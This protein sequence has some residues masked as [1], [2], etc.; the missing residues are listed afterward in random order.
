MTYDVVARAQVVEVGNRCREALAAGISNPLDAE[1]EHCFG[2]GTYARIMK[3]A[4]GSV[5]QG[6]SHLHSTITVMLKGRA[7]V[8][9][10]SGDKRLVCQGEVFSSPPG[11]SRAWVTAMGCTLMTIHHTA[12]VDTSA[13]DALDRLR[14]LLIA[15]E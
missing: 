3:V 12:G 2:T 10:S 15:E 5:I 8:I 13:P 14:E 1:Y 4:P 6:L 7:H 9:T 11:A